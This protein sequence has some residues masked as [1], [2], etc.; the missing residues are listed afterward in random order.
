MQKT[1]TS[2]H[3]Q[4]NQTYCS[5]RMTAGWSGG[6]A[7]IHARLEHQLEPAGLATCGEMCKTVIHVTAN[8]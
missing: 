2:L 7:L 4:E 6:P 1:E 5:E 3:F 8:I